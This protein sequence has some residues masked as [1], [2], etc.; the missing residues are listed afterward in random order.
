MGSSKI[1]ERNVGVELCSRLVPYGVQPTI[2]PRRGE[3]LTWIT[4]Y[5]SSKV[6][7]L[8]L[9]H[10]RSVFRH[11]GLEIEMFATWSG[12]LAFD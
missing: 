9:Y 1:E 2:I 11:E 10:F 12:A 6:V 3:P 8:F 4:A 5:D 7:W